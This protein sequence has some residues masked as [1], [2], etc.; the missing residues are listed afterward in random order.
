MIHN[1]NSSYDVGLV[2]KALRSDIKFLKSMGEVQPFDWHESSSFSTYTL[3]T[4]ESFIYFI[5]KT[6][7]W[8]ICNVQFCLHL[9]LMITKLIFLTYPIFL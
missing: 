9:N 3:T 8:R 6:S 7:L 4:M 1:N 2:V 5:C